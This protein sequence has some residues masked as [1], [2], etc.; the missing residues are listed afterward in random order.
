MLSG[1][2][3]VGR[4]RSED[5]V[6]LAQFVLGGVERLADAEILGGS[7]CV[8]GTRSDHVHLSGKIQQIS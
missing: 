7:Y 5:A 8:N 4:V 6:S 3:G 2:Q 1:G